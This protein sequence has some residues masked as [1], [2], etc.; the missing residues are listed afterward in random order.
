MVSQTSTMTPQCF[1]VTVS[2]C[3]KDLTI[4]VAAVLDSAL[5]PAALVKPS[6]TQT[7]NPSLVPTE[8]HNSASAFSEEDALSLPPHCPY[9]RA[10]ELLLGATLP[11]S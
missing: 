2:L 11:K 1:A 4:L 6:P 7:I 8:Y 5:S 10:I 9:D 3:L